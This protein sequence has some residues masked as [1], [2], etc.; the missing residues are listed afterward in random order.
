[1]R[2]EKNRTNFLH[3]LLI[4]PTFEGTKKIV[5]I[6]KSKKQKPTQGELAILKILWQQ[7]PSTVREVN[8][9]L[10]EREGEKSVT[11]TTTLKFMQVMHK[12]GFLSREREGAGHIYSPTITAKENSQELLDEIVETTFRGSTSKLVMQILGNHKTTPEELKEIREF[13]D[14]L[15]EENKDA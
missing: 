1:M 6:V 8:E 14:G 12:K 9:K 4:Y 7:G 13:L 15:D 11:Y 2:Y 10:N 3:I 5:P